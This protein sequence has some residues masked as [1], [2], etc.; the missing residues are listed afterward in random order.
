[1]RM[2]LVAGLLLCGLQWTRAQGVDP[3]LMREAAAVRAQVARSRDALRD[4]TWT[5]HTEVS[6]KG[7]VKSS[8]AATCRYNRNGEITKTPIGGA[9]EQKKPNASAKRVVTRKK[10]DM[11]DYIE[12]AVSTIHDYVPPKPEQIDHLLQTGSASL[13]QS[14]DGKT[15]V[16]LTNYYQE[17]DSLVITYDPASKVVLRANIASTLGSPKDPVTLE[18]IFE[19]LPDGVNHLSS[20][21][22][23]APSKKIQVKTRNVM[24]QKLAN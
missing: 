23:S 17:G 9:E 6:V 21:T 7:E 19:T 8:T 12:R 14:P 15:V 3:N 13:G 20:T 2:R 11:Q 24:Y 4:Y 10:A 22:L 16:R 5:E 18:A 1:M